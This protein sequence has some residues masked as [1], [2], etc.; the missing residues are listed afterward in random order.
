MTAG[1]TSLF[2]RVV[3][4]KLDGADGPIVGTTVSRK[5]HAIAKLAKDLASMYVGREVV[6]VYPTGFLEED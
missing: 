6:V 5:Q 1:P 2:H 4:F 3:L